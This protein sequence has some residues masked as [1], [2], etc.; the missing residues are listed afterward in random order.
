MKT[1]PFKGLL[2]CFSSS[3]PDL[4]SKLTKD[5]KGIYSGINFVSANHLSA[6]MFTKLKEGEDFVVD[7]CLPLQES[8]FLKNKHA[9]CAVTIFIANNSIDHE[10]NVKE[11]R[12]AFSD[13]APKF[14]Y[15]IVNKDK[16]DKK[17]L[18]ENIRH[19]MNIEKWRR[20]YPSIQ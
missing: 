15:V 10:D 6:E 16:K 8:N 18:I 3:T 12:R 4:L 19:I 5:L 1:K 2:L 14:D 20:M 7:S 17:T 9:E 11:D 13:S